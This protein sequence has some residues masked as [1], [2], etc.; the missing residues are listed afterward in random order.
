MKQTKFFMQLLLMTVSVY[1]FT[2]S[3][4]SVNPFNQYMSPTGGINLFSGNVVHSYPLFSLVSKNG[5]NFPVALGYSSNVDLNAR[6]KNTICSH[7]AGSI[8]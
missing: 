7:N 2:P 4:E 8:P 5:V 6:A 1:S 3:G